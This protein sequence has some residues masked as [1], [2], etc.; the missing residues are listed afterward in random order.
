MFP[1]SDLT[2]QEL[3]FNL[4]G[5]DDDI[6][7]LYEQC[8]HLNYAPFTYSEK[9]V[10][11]INDVDSDNNWY[12]IVNADSVYFTEDEFNKKIVPKNQGL[13][14]FSIIHFNVRSMSANFNK[15]KACISLL[16]CTFDVIAISETW[17]N[18]NDEFQLE[19]YNCFYTSRYQ[20]IGGGVA[21]YI[22]L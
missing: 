1:F 15:L 4:S 16:D 11:C 2:D 17:M 5:V 8:S 10:H 13:S 14:N 7:D 19:N 22:S 9:N 3:N 20:R 6:I 21:L 18:E 12:N